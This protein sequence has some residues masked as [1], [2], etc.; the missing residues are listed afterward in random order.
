MDLNPFAC[1]LAEMNL[2]IQGLDD[3][4]A[5]Q[6]VGEP[7][8]LDRFHIY[9][10]DSLNLPREVLDDPDVTG[11]AAIRVVAN[12]FSDRLL[13]EAYPIK[14]RLDDHAQGFYYVICNPPYVDSK[15][16]QLG[17]G[18]VKDSEFYKTVLSGATNLYL[19]FLRLGLYYVS[20]SGSM[21]YIAPLTMFGD[22][23]AGAL[24]K[25][26]TTPP[27]QP[28]AAIRFYRS[29]VLFPGVDQLVGIMRVDKM[30]PSSYLVVSGGETIEE[31]RNI[32]FRTN[33]S[34]VVEAV[35]YDR[36]WHG[37]WLLTNTQVS[38]DIWKVALS[39]SSALSTNLGLLL[40]RIF[41]IKQGDVNATIL[42]SIRRKSGSGD[43]SKGDIAIYKGEQIDILGSLP[44]IP[45]DWATPVP[46]G[47]ITY[48]G[49]VKRASEA[50][51]ALTQLTSKEMGVLVRQV[52]RLDTRERVIATWY[53]RD[54]SKPIAFTNELWRMSLKPNESAQLAKA[55]VALI[56][57]KVLAYLVNLFSTNNHVGKEELNRV[58]IPDPKTFPETEL[59]TLADALLTERATLQADFVDKYE[60]VLPEF[61]D[62]KVYV[63]PSTVLAAMPLS[64]LTIASLVS[65]GEVKNTGP[66]NGRIETLVR[67]GQIVSLLP[68]DSPDATAFATALAL[69]LHEPARKSET[70]AQVQSRQLPDPSLSSAWLNAYYDVV[71][72]AQAS[73]DRFVD[74]LRQVDDV[75]AQWYG[76]NSVMLTEIRA[77]LPWARRRRSNAVPTSATSSA[78]TSDT[79][80]VADLTPVTSSSLAAVGYDPVTQALKIQFIS[81]ESY[82]YELVPQEIYEGLLASA[83]QGSY[84]SDKIRG[85]YRS[86]KL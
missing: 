75:V 51:K 5:L 14:A 60:A 3:L 70:W 25:L 82:L 45:S 74:S 37:S 7:Q 53:E 24:R 46:D 77:G 39:H 13:D 61:E 55:L 56:C 52:A 81:G 20:E 16:E 30:K 34:K 43:Y 17:V 2:L 50:L 26:V 69:F 32:Q 72:K 68:A 84:Y 23:S 80:D 58:P 18:R 12:R 1:Y 67:N 41:D 57:S 62:E 33:L 19:M 8:P 42:N 35:P 4:F 65:R 44:S 36:V 59:A 86:Q 9:N 10:T 64:K 31:A 76:F 40:N 11:T 85:Q 28:T 63:P 47:S 21:V 22:K 79:A 73:W 15:Q 6:Q 71:S 29:N 49:D 27:F 78:E 83:S 38:L 54:S 48:I 66:V